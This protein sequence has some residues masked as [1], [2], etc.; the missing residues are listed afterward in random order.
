MFVE[1]LFAVL[2]G[3]YPTALQVARTTTMIFLTREMAWLL[4]FIWVKIF[5]CGASKYRQSL[6]SVSSVVL[7]A[8]TTIFYSRPIFLWEI[9][10]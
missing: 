5:C 4:I 2:V 3:L 1:R 8:Q 6:K 7:G 10:T 9:G